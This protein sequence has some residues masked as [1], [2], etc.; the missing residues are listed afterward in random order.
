V[1]VNKDG[2][3]PG[4]QTTTMGMTATLP[5]GA[6]GTVKQT[7]RVY[8]ADGT[9]KNLT[10]VFDKVSG[11]DNQ[12]T[13]SLAG[14]DVTAGS[15][16]SSVL[17]FSGNGVYTGSGLTTADTPAHG[18]ITFNVSWADGTSSSIAFDPSSLQQ[19]ASG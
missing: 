9:P 15:V 17:N 5:S 11:S 19:Y 3:M 13:L 14:S 12:W 4:Q 7:M 1:Y 10:M 8:G 18:D 2:I 6:T 16:S